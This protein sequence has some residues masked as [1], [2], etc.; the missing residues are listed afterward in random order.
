MVSDLSSAGKPSCSW[1]SNPPLQHGCTVC[2][3]YIQFFVCPCPVAHINCTH[4][5]DMKSKMFVRWQTGSITEMKA[6]SD[7]VVCVCYSLS[8][9]LNP[10]YS[11]QKQKSNSSLCMPAYTDKEKEMDFPALQ[12]VGSHMQT[13]VR[14]PIHYVFA[15]VNAG[16]LEI[17]Y[18]CH[19]CF[20]LRYSYVLHTLLFD[21]NGKYRKPAGTCKLYSFRISTKPQRIQSHQRVR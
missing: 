12:H 18:N 3:K 6:T 20:W 15:Y 2:I 16:H 19:F 11:C 9:L 17:N 1:V 13:L 10:T 5:W 7:K 8:P 4:V 21:L 14:L